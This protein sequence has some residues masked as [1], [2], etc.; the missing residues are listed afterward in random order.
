MQTTVARELEPGTKGSEIL[1][2]AEAVDVRIGSIALKK[3]S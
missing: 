3:G 2:W 1:P